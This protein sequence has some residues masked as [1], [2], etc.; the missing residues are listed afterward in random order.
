MGLSSSLFKGSDDIGMVYKDRN[1][2]EIIKNKNSGIS[3]EELI[4]F[5]NDVN[6]LIDLE[7]H[8]SRMSYQDNSNSMNILRRGKSHELYMNLYCKDENTNNIERMIQTMD[9][10]ETCIFK[11]ESDMRNLVFC[12]NISID[13]RKYKNYLINNMIIDLSGIKKQNKP[14]VGNKI[15]RS[16]DL[17]DISLR[18]MCDSKKGDSLPLFPSSIYTN[19]IV[20]NP[21]YSLS[22][23]ISQNYIFEV[24]ENVDILPLIGYEFFIDNISIR[25][26]PN[27]QNLSFLEC[28]RLSLRKN[29]NVHFKIIKPQIWIK[30]I[31][32]DRNNFGVS[33][34]E[35]EKIEEKQ[36]YFFIH[37][38][39]YC[40]VIQGTINITNSNS[41]SKKEIWWNFEI[42][43]NPEGYD[44][45]HLPLVDSLGNGLLKLEKWLLLETVKY[46]KSWIPFIIPKNLSEYIT[47]MPLSEIDSLMTDAYL[48]WKNRF[49]VKSL[50]YYN[51]CITLLI[52]EKNFNNKSFLRFLNEDHISN[53]IICFSELLSQFESWRRTHNI[54][55]NYF[56]EMISL[57]CINSLLISDYLLGILNLFYKDSKLPI[58]L[59]Y[60][61]DNQDN[62]ILE[63][64][65]KYFT[66][67]IILAKITTLRSLSLRFLLQY[68]SK[69]FLIKYLNSRIQNISN[70]NLSLINI[71]E[72]ILNIITNDQVISSAIETFACNLDI[73]RIL[74]MNCHIPQAIT[75]DILIS[76]ILFFAEIK[77]D[78]ST[79]IFI[80]E[81][82]CEEVGSNIINDKDI[83]KDNFAWSDYFKTSEFIN[84]QDFIKSMDLIL[85][86]DDFNIH[87]DY[88]TN[89]YI[90]SNNIE[91]LKQRLKRVYESL[92][93]KIYNLKIT[94][95]PEFI[96]FLVPKATKSV[97]EEMTYLRGTLFTKTNIYNIINQ[98]D[99]LFGCC[100]NQDIQ[101]GS[102]RNIFVQSNISSFPEVNKSLIQNQYFISSNSFTSIENNWNSINIGR[103]SFKI[104]SFI[105]SL[106]TGQNGG[107]QCCNTDHTDFRNLL[108]LA[109]VGETHSV[110][111]TWNV[112]ENSE[113]NIPIENEVS[114]K[115]AEELI[116]DWIKLR[117][118][119]FASTDLRWIDGCRYIGEGVYETCLMQISPNM[120]IEDIVD[121]IFQEVYHSEVRKSLRNI[122]FEAHSPLILVRNFVIPFGE[123]LIPNPNIESLIEVIKQISYI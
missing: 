65:K 99:D 24:P 45:I 57:I 78:I 94:L 89:I 10:A 54:N 107:I 23:I 123:L 16:D 18:Y 87:M 104:F 46:P 60:M 85:L 55:S 66:L 118:W 56:I 72:N 86:D 96:K 53:Y 17:I 36:N 31:R 113:E 7:F 98:E 33:T 122:T 3:N 11:R 6:D 81:M 25:K 88:L 32:D 28:L 102:P 68:P 109:D 120:L 51:T 9:R 5:S 77:Q 84:I 35:Y 40:T 83:N 116:L 27:L 59:I 91:L 30:P 49:L 50:N 26:S 110:L 67:L 73:I 1:C 4:S 101:Q 21:W 47:L 12:N 22:S 13:E 103:S 74:K 121:K 48:L 14:Y 93:I 52:D 106:I 19:N 20:T 70:N 29:R 62:D 2:G 111:P 69:D 63:F 76:S 79:S 119:N 115:I 92:R 71:F 61:I 112:I 15:L 114:N 41:N 37:S 100:Q 97:K 90:N 43:D 44:T 75:L 42:E 34:I 39:V 108:D 105:R 8:I 82:F 80:G 117:C 95:S 38:L 64:N 58:A